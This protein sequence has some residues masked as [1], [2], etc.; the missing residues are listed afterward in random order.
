MTK[1]SVANYLRWLNSGRKTGDWHKQEEKQD[2][3]E[4]SG[5][6]KRN[7]KLQRKTGKV[8]LET[9]IWTK[10]QSGTLNDIYEL[11]HNILC[12]FSTFV[13]IKTNVPMGIA[14]ITGLTLILLTL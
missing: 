6:L 11:T 1:V 5:T 13:V 3:L 10:E 4:E 2:H 8:K 12:F 9:G 7:W 14:Q